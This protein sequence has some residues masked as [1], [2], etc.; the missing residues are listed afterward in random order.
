MNGGRSSAIGRFAQYSVRPKILGSRS[1]LK[2]AKTLAS[3]ALGRLELVERVDVEARDA[4]R[5]IA[6]LRR[7]ALDQGGRAVAA[8]Q[9]GAR[10]EAA[11]PADEPSRLAHSD[12]R[13]DAKEPRARDRPRDSD[14]DRQSDAAGADGSDPPCDHAGVEAELADDVRRER[15]LLEHH[16]DRRLVADEGVA[17]RVAG[18]AHLV[19]SVLELG[20][21][22][23]QSGR[24]GELP[25]RH[26]HVAGNREDVADADRPQP[27][28]DV[29][30]VLLVPDETGR[31]LRRISE[32]RRHELLAETQ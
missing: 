25:R 15:L 31:E 6:E 14:E 3:P 7:Q 29:P 5:G 22:F 11:V 30:E 24:A 13:R 32:R 9:Q 8:W 26:V 1:R 18:D 23:E 2:T 19:D 4:A 10:E 21:R 12:P 17:L 28:E 20:H 16:L 27:P